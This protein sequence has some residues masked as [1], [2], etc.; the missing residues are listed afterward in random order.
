MLME[1]DILGF[2]SLDGMTKVPIEINCELG[3]SWCVEKKYDFLTPL[4]MYT[5]IVPFS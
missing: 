3:M 2:I 4:E 1:G 5:K